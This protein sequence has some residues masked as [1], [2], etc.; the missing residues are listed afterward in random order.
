M[1]FEVPRI[2]SQK[3]KG[4]R[5]AVRGP[6]DGPDGSGEVIRSGKSPRITQPPSRSAKGRLM[7]ESQTG[8]FRRLDDTPDSSLP[9]SN[10]PA[11][12]AGCS[13]S[14]RPK[15]ASVSRTSRSSGIAY[16]A[17]VGPTEVPR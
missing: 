6:T 1:S 5:Q 14:S 12:A 3:L 2:R 10:A 16:N 8:R 7:V 13:Q 15:T 11:S 9:H 4:N 17:E